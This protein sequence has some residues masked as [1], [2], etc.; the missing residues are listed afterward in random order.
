MLKN[1]LFCLILGLA[2]ACQTDPEEAAYTRPNVPPLESPV[3]ISRLEQQLFSASSP[4]EI[5]D[6]L[7][8]NKLFAQNFLNSGQYPSD[9]VLAQQLFTLIQNPALDTLYRQTQSKFTDLSGWEDELS[10]AFATVRY[11]WPEFVVPQVVTTVS[12]L[13]AMGNE[14]AISDS[15]LV[16]SL[17]YF[18]GEEAAY[19][20]DFPAYILQRFAPDYAVPGAMV[21]LSTRFN[22]VNPKDNSLVG[23]MIYYGKSYYFAK[24]LLPNTP[25]S[26]ITGFTAEQ[27]A[28]VA[29]NQERIWSHFL[30]KE[31]LYTT[32]DEDKRRYLGERPTVPE[33][34]D[35]A[36]GRVGYWIGWEIVKSHMRNQEEQNLRKLMENQD[37]RQIFKEARYIPKDV[38][39]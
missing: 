19:R 7:Q 38:R 17:D 39:K 14:Y 15:L 32:K 35:K 27:Q 37:A 16:I 11:Y 12:G 29:Y 4:G 21:L 28:G 22:K 20:P 26:L 36:P 33:I 31:L 24:F 6:F 30:D 2:L 18:L 25:D 1:I 34:G 10:Q 9:S 5:T 13:G 8:D 23:D 3:T